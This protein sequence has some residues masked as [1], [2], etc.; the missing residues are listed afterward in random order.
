MANATRLCQAKMGVMFLCEGDGFRS[1]ALHGVSPAH[2]EDRRLAPL[3]HPGP[4]VPL[5][6][7]ARTRQ[8]IHIAD[9]RNEQAYIEG[10]PSFVALVD[11]GGARTLLMIPMLREDELVGAISIHRQEVRPFTDKQIELVQNF[12]TQAVIAIENTRLL[13]AEHKRIRELTE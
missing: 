1:V 8:T 2:A 9:I 13:E 4:E 5:G 10:F 3:I 6:R 7:L 11:A 12:A